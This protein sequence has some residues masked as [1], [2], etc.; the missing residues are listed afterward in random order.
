MKL[1]ELQY[2]RILGVD[3]QQGVGEPVSSG[4]SASLRPLE[5][6]SCERG[7]VQPPLVIGSSAGDHFKRFAAKPAVPASTTAIRIDILRADP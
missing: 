5:D 4:Y 6:F 3:F 7:G 2:P 1:K